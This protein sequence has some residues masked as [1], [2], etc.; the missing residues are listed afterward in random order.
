MLH[1]NLEDPDGTLAMLRDSVAALAERMPGPDS[2]RAKR[3][4]G[5][6]IDPALWKAMAE[7]GWTALMLPEELGGLGLGLAEQAVLSEALG[8]HLLSEPI[9]GGAVLVSS[10]LADAPDSEERQR[11]AGSV[12]AGDLIAVAHVNPPAT[13]SAKPA[14]GAE[15]GNGGLVISG[16]KRLVDGAASAR[17]FLV[18]VETGSGAALASVPADTAGLALVPHEG[19]DG[20]AIFTVRFDGV[21][22]PAERVLA[23]A[24]TVEALMDLPT[25]AA[26]IALAAELAGV[27]CRAVEMTVNY[28]KDRVQFGKP[29]ASFQA[30]QHRMVEMWSDAEFACA[31]VV[32]AVV[33]QGAGDEAE[34]RLAILAAKAR[35]GDAATSI[36]RRSVHLHGAMGFTD[37]AQIGLYLKRALSLNASLGQPE[38]LRLQFVDIELAA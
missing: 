32:N 33:R 23:R 6:D 29:I 14:T 28:T 20:A 35:A 26:R 13:S 9:S 19:V 7:A 22:V 15:A 16:E 25:R 17:D 2:V 8:R 3:G 4:K 24:E 36:C 34:A 11:L 30:L 27:A 12:V 5:A 10:L 21:E 37:E 1:I 31:A 18:V 38:Q